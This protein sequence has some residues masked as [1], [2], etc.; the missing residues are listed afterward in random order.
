M[1]ISCLSREMRTPLTVTTC[2][3]RH[4]L[5]LPVHGRS[6]FL[7]GHAL[8]PSHLFLF[9]HVSNSPGSLNCFHPTPWTRVFL[10]QLTVSQLVKKFP[11]FYGTRKFITEC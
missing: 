6:S 7:S 5:I 9:S 8:R 4:L 11:T 10:E 3:V 2:S 1:G